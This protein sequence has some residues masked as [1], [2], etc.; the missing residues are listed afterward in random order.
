VEAKTSQINVK[1]GQAQVPLT[2]QMLE[3]AGINKY[4]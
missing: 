2:Q 1:L 4:A 3:L